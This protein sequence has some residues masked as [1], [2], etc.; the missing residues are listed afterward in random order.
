MLH[1]HFSL[2]LL[3]NIKVMRPLSK[4][5]FVQC[6]LYRYTVKPVYK[7]HSRE[8]AKTVIIDRWDL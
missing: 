3:Y 4:A 8:K 6:K 5:L 2:I 7:D 1:N